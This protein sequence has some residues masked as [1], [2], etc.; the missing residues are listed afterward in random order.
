M[1]DSY[2]NSS[3][4]KTLV[5]NILSDEH[6][7]ETP[8][9]KIT[10]KTDA[11]YSRLDL[12]TIP[13]QMIYDIHFTIY[14]CCIKDDC[15][16]LGLDFIDFVKKITQYCMAT[17]GFNI[18]Q[19]CEV[20]LFYANHINWLLTFY[21]KLSDLIVLDWFG[22]FSNEIRFHI[23]ELEK[24]S[25]LSLLH[26]CNPLYNEAKDLM[27]KI[28]PFIKLELKTIMINYIY[29]INSNE[30]FTLSL[31]PESSFIKELPTMFSKNTKG[32]DITKVYAEMIFNMNNICD[33][34]D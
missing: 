8:E 22:V 14:L 27:C 10:D 29:M 18:V 3:N 24:N 21:I 28:R 20:M 31:L 30:G 5:N 33:I 4:N 16:F 15:R 19:A 32:E 17:F 11:I 12:P 2:V 34:Y 26:P 13:K 25:E 7:Q 6:Y 9:D 23:A 1:T